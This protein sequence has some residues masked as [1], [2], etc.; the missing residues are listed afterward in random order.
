MNVVYWIYNILKKGSIVKLQSQ[1]G[2]MRGESDDGEDM[3]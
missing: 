3:L 1:D 2:S